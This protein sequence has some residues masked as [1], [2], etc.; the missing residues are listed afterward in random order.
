MIENVLILDHTGVSNRLHTLHLMYLRSCCLKDP[1]R[2]IFS[3]GLNTLEMFHA[4]NFSS[5]LC[6]A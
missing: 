4:F 6:V 3:L 2:L 5:C 1:V